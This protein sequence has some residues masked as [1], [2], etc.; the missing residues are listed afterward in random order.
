LRS[1][2]FIFQSDYYHGLL[3]VVK[4]ALDSIDVGPLKSEQG[5]QNYE[6][7]AATDLTKYDAVVVYGERLHAVFGWAKLEP[8]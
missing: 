2:V 3:G 7:P 4:G 1:H 8:F 6:V 5:D